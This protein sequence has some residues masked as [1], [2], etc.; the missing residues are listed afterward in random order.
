[1]K[2]FAFVL[3]LVVASTVST[4]GCVR[5]T[6]VAREPR[7][8][9]PRLTVETFNV[10]FGIPG[11]PG[12]LAAIAAGNADVVFLQET[13]G[14]WE[15]AIRGSGFAAEYPHM[16]FHHCCGAG[17]LAVLSRL[18]F[19]AEVLENT[20]ES[21]WFPALRAVVKTPI[22]DVQ[23]LSVHLRP[24]LSPSGGVVSGYLTTP[25]VRKEEIENYYGRLDPLLPTLVVGDF[26][27]SRGGKAVAF[28]AAH[29]MRSALEEFDPGK[30]TW[31]WPTLVGQVH[32][33]LD[34]IVYDAKLEP[35]RMTVLDQGRS[36]HLPVVGVFQPAP[37]LLTR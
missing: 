30:K 17:G 18:P 33:T 5:A 11:D 13:N 24:Q 29:G 35:L 23:V 21:G 3:A 32:Q 31:H 25:K 36:D 7:P 1:M 4:A 22:G 12:T 34:H 9:S 14:A 15:D 20:T 2:P 8:G 26:N 37:G 16:E 10:N 6:R 28:L 19:E 27:E